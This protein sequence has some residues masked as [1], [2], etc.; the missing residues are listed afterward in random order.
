MHGDARSFKDMF[1]FFYWDSL[2]Q[3]HSMCP[4][5]WDENMMMSY[6]RS[7]LVQI[8][9]EGFLSTIKPLNFAREL[10]SLVMKIREIKHQQKFKVYIDSNSKSSRLVKLSICK[11]GSSFQL[12]KLSHHKIEVLLSNWLFCS[13]VYFNSPFLKSV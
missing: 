7:L 1:V 12:K 9:F 11:N 8:H 2:P 3:N 10:I 6:R 5:L 4:Y 13:V